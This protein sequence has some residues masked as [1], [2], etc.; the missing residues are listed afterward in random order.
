MNV[1]TFPLTTERWI[2]AEIYC[3]GKHLKVSV[4]R[5][6]FHRRPKAATD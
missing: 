6:S 2:E 3:W 1:R 5:L 4:T